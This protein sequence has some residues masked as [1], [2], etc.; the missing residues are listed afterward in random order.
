VWHHAD[1][2]RLGST[3]SPRRGATRSRTPVV[4]RD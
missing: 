2:P 1:E 3:V 4:R